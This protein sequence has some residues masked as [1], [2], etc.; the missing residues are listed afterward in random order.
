MEFVLVSP[1]ETNGG[2]DAIYIFP[3]GTSTHIAFDLSAAPFNRDFTGLLPSSVVYSDSKSG[4]AVL[5]G[6]VLTVTYSTAPS[7]SFFEAVLTLHYPSR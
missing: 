3:D 4:S 5:S 6:T 2:Q 7:G 1:A